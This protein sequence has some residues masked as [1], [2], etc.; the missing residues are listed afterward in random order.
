MSELKPNKIEF[1]NG[2]VIIDLTQD[3]VTPEKMYAG[4]T[5][6]DASGEI[7]TGTA[8]VTDDGQGNVTLPAGLLTLTGG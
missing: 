8:E 1:P 5:A 7:I 3:T 2:T 4:I 6:H